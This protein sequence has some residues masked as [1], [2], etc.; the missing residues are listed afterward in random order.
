M[1]NPIQEDLL[2]EQILKAAMQLYQQ[3]GIKKVTMD[4]VAKMVGK[5]RSSLYYYYKNRDEIFDAVMVM[6]LREIIDEIHQAM[7]K[8]Q[9]TKDKIK[10]FC[11]AK[12]KTSEERKALYFAIE[13]ET[14]IDEISRHSKVMMD[15]HKQLMQLESSLL[16]KTLSLAIKSEEVR[17]LKPKESEMLIFILLSGI[18]GIKREMSYDNNFGKL[19]YAVNTLVD[20]A[21]QWLHK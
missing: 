7:D 18:R 3:H 12:V 21:M 17:T 14:N 19:D 6:L 16:K 11:L 9:N 2:P 10:A 15:L 1:A 4:D 13:S 5:T 20:M 8:A